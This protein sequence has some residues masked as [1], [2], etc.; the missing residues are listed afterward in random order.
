MSKKSEKKYA[1]VYLHILRGH[2]KFH[3]KRIFF[4]PYAKNKNRHRE[5]VYLIPIFL[6]LHRPYKKSAFVENKFLGT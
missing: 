4:V 1:H 6:F 5:K 2:P 3:E